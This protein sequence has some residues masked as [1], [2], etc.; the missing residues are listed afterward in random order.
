[1]NDDG[2]RTIFRVEA[3]RRYAQGEDKAVPLQFTSPRIIRFLWGLIGLLLVGGLLLWLMRVPV[4]TS[5]VAVPISTGYPS[6][7]SPSVSHWNP[8]NEPLVAVFLPSN[9]ISQLHVG[10]RVFWRFSKTDL[11]VSRFVLEVSLEV[12]S[13]YELQQ[14]FGLRGKAA[15]AISEPAVVAFAKL[16]PVPNALPAP[17]YLGTVYP[18]EVEV[19]TRRVISFLPLVGRFFSD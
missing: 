2:Q 13:P 10:Q 14:K 12:N 18:A 3:L 17:A 11:R 7:A 5:G 19:G 15:S 8:N 1:M 9:S 4:Y 16:Q 6:S